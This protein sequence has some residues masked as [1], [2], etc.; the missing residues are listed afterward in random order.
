L[1]SDTPEVAPS[2]SPVRVVGIMTL[3]LWPLYLLLYAAKLYLNLSDDEP[4]SWTGDVLLALQSPAILAAVFFTLLLAT[5][6]IIVALK[7]RQLSRAR[8]DLDEDS[9]P[10]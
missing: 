4:F 3:R 5:L 10:D 7:R 9:A 2:A 8:S 1:E 6:Q